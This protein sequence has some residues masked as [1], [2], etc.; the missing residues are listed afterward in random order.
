M[1]SRNRHTSLAPVLAAILAP[2]LAT[3]L[4]LGPALSAS[5]QQKEFK[6]GDDG[7]WVKTREVDPS[8]DEGRI[9]R[10]KQA[11]AENR[12]SLALKQMN[13]WIER[14]SR[15]DNPWLAEAYLIR[16]DAKT[17]LGDEYKALY[18]YE[19][20]CKEFPGTEQFATAVERE[21]D[22]GMR[23]L[24]GLKRKFLGM[25]IDGAT[26]LGEELLLRTQERMPGSRIAERACI[27]LADY[28]YRIRDLKMAAETY[29][30]FLRSYPNSQ[31]RPKAMQRR[32]YANIGRFKGPLYDASGLLEAKLLIEDFSESYPADA[33]AA[34]LSDALVAR[35][36]ESA[37]AQMYETAKWY[38]QRSDPVSAKL[39][40]RRLM[41]R[42]P[43]SVAAVRAMEL[44][45]ARGWDPAEFTPPAVVPA[46]LPAGGGEPVLDDRPPGDEQPPV[47]P[48]DP[49]APPGDQPPADPTVQPRP[50][51][52]PPVAPPAL[53]KPD[54]ETTPKERL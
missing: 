6:L 25:R 28:Y 35:L 7:S 52:Q 22:I 26:G 53:P 50:S 21:M 3:F 44:I 11:L 34:G 10:A 39:T 12:P 36:D 14:N 40:L 23:Y 27:E 42:H 13:D 54:P 20:V 15:T 30:I 37:A 17:A 48:P 45:K 8:S 19:E 4:V 47:G 24:N 1:P 33:E 2:V 43:D 29:D 32:V 9:E 49:A 31:Y 51:G 41:R 18:D 5:A 38:L 16:A 46:E